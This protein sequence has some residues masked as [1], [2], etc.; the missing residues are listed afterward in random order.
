M[1]E[2]LKYKGEIKRKPRVRR[3]KEEN[4]KK[5]IYIPQYNIGKVKV[6]KN[7]K[8]KES[9]ISIDLKY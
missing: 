1:A 3:C 4:R 7:K 8:K 5:E 2:N 6:K 9:V